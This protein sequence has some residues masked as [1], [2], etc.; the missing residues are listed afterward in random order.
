MNVFVDS[1][2]AFVNL[3]RLMLADGEYVPSIVF[4]VLLFFVPLRS[5]YVN[6]V[7]ALFLNLICFLCKLLVK[8]G[9]IPPIAR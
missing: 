5:F 4:I 3:N 8:V 2:F 7:L 9:L 6:V 1:W